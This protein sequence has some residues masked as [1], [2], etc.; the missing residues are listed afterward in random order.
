[1]Y[2]QETKKELSVREEIEKRERLHLSPYACLSA[3]TRGRNKLIEPC[4]IRSEFQ[5]DRDR[6]VY[7]K[8]FRR[9]KHKTQVFLSPIGDHCRTRLTHTLEV[10][11]IART[12]ARALSLNEDLVEAI[13]LGHDLGHTPFGHAG[14]TV[15]NQLFPGGFSHNYQ[16]LRVVETLENNGMGLNLTFE[17][18][19]GILKH[20]KGYGE[21]IPN[22]SHDLPVTA[23]GCLVRYADIIAYLSH[24]LDDAIRSSVI[25]ES[26]V[27]AICQDV[28]G[29]KH[30]RRTEVM[31]Q[32]VLSGTRP[33]GKGL[34]FGV[35]D[36]VGKVMQELRQFLYYNVYRS[37]RVHSEFVKASKILRELYLY[38]LENP[39]V[40][41]QEIGSFAESIS[42][43]R[44]VCDFIASMTDRYAQNMYQRF[45]WP[46]SL[47]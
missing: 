13:S 35:E 39:E 5:R 33:G 2:L 24:D 41:K 28:L 29:R 36:K 14:E 12:L 7:S 27:P 23:E 20:S 44:R 21:V 37:S 19:D 25:R 15:L 4:P 16:S 46:E 26:D 22:N 10:S 9:L 40:F 18:R 1:M 42:L 30:S 45:F 3:E 43:E 32:G 34:I 8:A 11:E 38:L 17:V 47:A 6:I 31:I